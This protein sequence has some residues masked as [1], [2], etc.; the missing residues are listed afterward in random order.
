[1][2]PE[3]AVHL[4]HLAG[5]Q[6]PPVEVDLTNNFWGTTDPAQIA[7]WILDGNDDPLHEGVVIYEPFPPRDEI[8]AAT[9]ER[10]E[11][12]DRGLAAYRRDD[13]QQAATIFES[14]RGGPDD[15]LVAHYLER[16]A[17]R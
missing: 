12:Y 1:M 8:D 4:E 9:L 10:L 17:G 3:D 14:L 7:E 2:R 15:R 5:P 13:P 16:I 6:R 11:R